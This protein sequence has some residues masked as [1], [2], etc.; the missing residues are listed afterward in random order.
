M[1]VLGQD[2]RVC[3]PVVSPILS[4]RRSAL[5]GLAEMW[6]RWTIGVH[7]VVFVLVCV[8]VR[9]PARARVRAHGLECAGTRVDVSIQGELVFVG[10]WL[11]PGPAP[12]TSSAAHTRV[13]SWVAFLLLLSCWFLLNLTCLADSSRSLSISKRVHFWTI[14]SN[15]FTF[16]FL[17]ITYL[18]IKL[19]SV[20]QAK[21]DLF[22]SLSANK[23]YI[24]QDRCLWK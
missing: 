17:L 21:F 11:H 6:W 9:E 2:S 19:N 22:Y 16:S 20:K 8:R 12:S 23:H 10:E 3:L 14:F 18:F 13:L 1:R 24:F 7:V 15:F 5:A 4:R